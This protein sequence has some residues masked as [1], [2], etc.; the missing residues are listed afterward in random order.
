MEENKKLRIGII[1]MGRISWAHTG[2]LSGCPDAVITAVCDINPD[3][4]NSAGDRLNI[5]AERRFTDY[6]DLIACPEVDAVEICTPNYLHVPMA[7]DVIRAGKPVNIEK[8]LGATYEGVP[9][10]ARS[11][12]REP[13]AEHDVFLLPLHAGGQIR[14]RAA[15]RETARK[16]RFGRRRIPSS[17][18]R[19]FEGRRLEWRIGQEEGGHRSYRR[20]RRS[21]DQT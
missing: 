19:S 5:P 2:G 7:T 17:P 9:E 16:Y 18:A 11:I 14:E 21:P 6:H 8:P 4:L 1:G 10:T 15:R 3:A 12:Q 13:A 20:P